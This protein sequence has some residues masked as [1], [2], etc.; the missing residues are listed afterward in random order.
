MREN[1]GMSLIEVLITVAIL[2][3]VI[4]TAGAFM[5]TSSRSFAKG[6]A[7]SDVQDEAELAVNQIEDLII[8]VN[9]GVSMTDDSA[10]ME[11]L[12]YH[13]EDTGSGSVYKKRTVTWDKASGNMQCSEWNMVYDSTADDYVV[14][15]AAVYADQLLADNV[16]N[17]T[18]DLSDKII[19][20]GAAKDGG[21]LTI[22]RS[23]SI[24]VD[25]EDGTGAAAYATSPII[26]LR[27][28]LMMGNNAKE[29][30]QQTPTADTTFQ[31]YISND[32][33][34]T[35][36]PIIDRVT[37][38]QRTGVYH[39][40]AM[41]NLGSCINDQVEWEIGEAGSLSVINADGVLS[42]GEYEPNDY[43]T[44]TAKYKSDPNKKATGV[45][46]V[47]GDSKTL[48]VMITTR[49]LEPFQPKYGSLIDA[50][51]YTE[52]EIKN[53]QY[54]WTVSEPERVEGFTDNGEEL[55]LTVKQEPENY[56]V[57]ITIT[58]T[59]TSPDTGQYASDSVVYRI[60]DE[61]VTGGDSHMMRGY[62]GGQPGYGGLAW[63]TFKTPFWTESVDFDYYF[64]DEH[65]N[66]ISAYDN[67]LQY[68]L[69]D[70]G[71][72]KSQ[73]NAYWLTFTKDLPPDRT[74]FIKVLCTYHNIYDVRDPKLGYRYEDVTYERIHEISAVQI[75]GQTT[76][77]QN[78]NLNGGFNFY[79]SLIGYYAL[80][81]RNTPYVFE[82]SV[83]DL[84]Y[85]APEG[86][87]VTCVPAGAE[88]RDNDLIQAF[89]SFT[90][91]KWEMAGQVTLKSAKIKIYMKDY[92]NICSYATVIFD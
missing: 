16:T 29:I 5:T 35:A 83:E 11:L 1:R 70:T 33:V 59:V 18:V 31:L 57:Y 89:G 58:L 38:V 36:V 20:K 28:R 21:D 48:G 43:L 76:H 2:S 67:L 87:V 60:D 30:F 3:I 47:V 53:L 61:Y 66:R 65:G 7:D 37:E 78:A 90:C 52:Q 41:V 77:V 45:V 26:T 56:G 91:N 55:E 84:V 27:N 71:G 79:Y 81:W 86:V 8:D 63:F 64:C 82:Y 54:L 24:R 72:E 49:S 42:V 85:D 80:S 44:I 9:G 10:K 6:S 92:P 69:I 19:E 75:Y 39:I 73:G 51:D 88:A 14:D 12:L 40:Y 62:E 15:G 50:P 17:F 4:V 34:A 22:V 23:V 68:I 74:F 46:K 13:A 25:C 32:T